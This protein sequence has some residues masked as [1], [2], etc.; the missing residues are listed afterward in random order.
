MPARCVT[1]VTTT[2]PGA[3][4][5]LAVTGLLNPNNQEFPVP[6]AILVTG[7]ASTA[8]AVAYVG[9]KKI[10]KWAQAR[11]ESERLSERL[12]SIALK[13]ASERSSF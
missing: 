3:C 11:R 5:A 1:V 13:P 9:K 4:N 10:E 12:D 7:I 6:V 8:A 2:P